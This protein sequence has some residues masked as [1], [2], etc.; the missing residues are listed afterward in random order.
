MKPIPT[1]LSFYVSS[2]ICSW[3]CSACYSR[4]RSMKPVTSPPFI[5]ALCMEAIFAG[6]EMYCILTSRRFIKAKA[7][8]IRSKRKVAA[9]SRLAW[10]RYA[11]P[12]VRL[13]PNVGLFHPTCTRNV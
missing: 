9:S 3:I 8:H 4:C 13:V 12:I 1:S 5:S 10:D 7:L 6:H 2:S 11:C